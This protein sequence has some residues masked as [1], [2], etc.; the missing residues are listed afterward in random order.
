MISQGE[1]WRLVT[2]VFLHES[3]S[4]FF[5]NMFM[6]ILIGPGAERM[7]KPVRFIILYL[8]SGVGANILAFFF[9]PAL[10]AYLGASGAILGVLGFFVFCMMYRKHVLSYY[11]EKTIQAFAVMSLISTF[12]MPNVGVIGHLGGFAIGFI[13][14]SQFI[15]KRRYI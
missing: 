10:Y 1:V 4:H 7:L 8:F 3:F 12:L 13:V 9:K 14:A 6:L 2:S 11:D 5:F 15:K